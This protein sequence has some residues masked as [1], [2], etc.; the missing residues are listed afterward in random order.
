MYALSEIKK[1]NRKA[2]VK[3][4]KRQPYIAG[5]ITGLND[6][7]KIPNFGDYRPKG[8]EETKSYF[9][10]HSGFGSDGE[11]A[12]TIGNFLGKMKSGYGYAITEVGQF[13][14]YITEF[15]KCLK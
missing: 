12:L 5:E 4:K 15:K 11:S 3:A 14:L 13:Q 6:L 2:G 1:M 7:K 9:V 8:W 10:D